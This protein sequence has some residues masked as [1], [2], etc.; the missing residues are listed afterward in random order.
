MKPTLRA[1]RVYQETTAIVQVSIVKFKSD[2]SMRWSKQR[3]MKAQKKRSIPSSFDQIR[4]M[5]T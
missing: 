1:F 2:F 4:S 3:T 5:I